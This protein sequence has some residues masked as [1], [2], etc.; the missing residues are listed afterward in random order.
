LEIPVLHRGIEYT[1]KL[2]ATPGFWRWEFCIGDK[3]RVGETETRREILAKRRAQMRI[4][5]EFSKA[6][7]RWDYLK[8]SDQRKV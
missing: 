8:V 7:R 1:L 4:D 2:A 5:Q 3:V 6:P